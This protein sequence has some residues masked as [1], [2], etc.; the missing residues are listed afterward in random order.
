M[1]G[2]KVISTLRSLHYK[3][4]GSIRDLVVGKVQDHLLRVFCACS[5]GV[6]CMFR[7]CYVHVLWVF[8]GCLASVLSSYTRSEGHGNLLNE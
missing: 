6:L 1:Q 4:A 5:V 8:C 3:V 2:V 7:G